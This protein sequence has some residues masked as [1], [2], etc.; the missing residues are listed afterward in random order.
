MLT[1]Q[2][3]NTVS[4]ITIRVKGVRENTIKDNTFL[5]DGVRYRSGS[6]HID[7][8]IRVK[9]KTQNDSKQANRTVKM[10]CFEI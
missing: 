6:A 2:E 10:A 3:Q 1:F 5:Y 9:Q 4:L 7:N 8:L